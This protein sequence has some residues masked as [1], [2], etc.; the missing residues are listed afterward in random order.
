MENISRRHFFYRLSALLLTGCGGREDDGT[1][2]SSS[3]TAAVSSDSTNSTV[4]IE[5]AV[6]VA[7]VHPG[8][9]HTD[10]DF[11]RMRNKV[12][13][14]ASPWID[15]WN[16]LVDNYHAS[17][18]RNPSPCAVISRG[19]DHDNY[20]T[21]FND[22]AAAYACALRWKVS[23]DTAYAEHAVKYLDEWSST[24]TALE[25]NSNVVLAAGI[26]GYELAN[27]GEIVR[28]YPGW[29]A[30][31]LTRFQKMMRT[32]F[33]PINY[34][35]LNGHNG[36]DITHYWANW[37][38]CSIA[39]ILAIGVL[40]D[41]A[42]L[43]N[44]AIFYFKNGAGNGCIEQAVYYVHPGNLGQWQES[45]RDQGHN[46]MGIALGGAI[47]EMAWNQN[48]DLYGYD[49]NRFLAGA[50]YVAKTNLIQS[51]STYYTVPYVTYQ[52]VDV[53]QTGLSTVAQ[54]IE[55]P[56]WALVANHYINRKGLAAPY[57]KKFA[58]LIEPEGGGG[59]YGPNSGGFDQLGYGTLTCTRDPGT[60]VATPI[61]LI[62]YASAGRVVLSWWGTSNA[63]SYNVKRAM[64]SGGPYTT[65]RIGI[66]DPLTFTD[67]PPSVGTYYY[68]VTAVTPSGETKPS[69]ERK[70]VTALHVQTYLA[71]D[72]TSGTTAADSSANGHTGTLKG[73]AA[74]AAGHA[75]N[76]VSLNGAG[77]Y[78]ALPSN[79]MVNLSDFTISAWVLWN[80]S[81]TW[82]RIFD[83]GAG[84]GRYLTLMPCNGAGVMEFATTV[85]GPHGT[86]GVTGASALPV[87]Q[88][89]HVAVTLSGTTATL[90][91]NGRAV[92]ANTE[93]FLAPFRLGST[94][95]N[96]LGRSQFAADPTFNGRIDEFRIHRGAL[97]AAQVASLT[98]S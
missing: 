7:F 84:T 66:T 12:A 64:I 41:D 49:N 85:N 81:Q 24:L 68:V 37:D 57:S 21:L 44:E 36:T 17:L 86:Q 62:G 6:T 26:Y 75:G 32:I 33:Y 31:G 11:T 92:N 94:N 45:G 76:A 35:F 91:V 90:Y 60:P 34:A 28:S 70:V 89:T 3:D 14:K 73:G 27:V 10:V 98:N 1:E 40:C 97:T 8:L 63:R 58:D 30:A 82:A 65:I 93:M 87:G 25:G 54:G 18:S 16:M 46:T 88:W 95:Q 52:N 48:V 96:W 50:E 59:N 43:F 79:L 4:A 23:D 39:S 74:R 83:F 22:V 56:C 47:C 72:E 15:G 38:L 20:P 5:A 29:S 9:L 61:N 71:F 51:G 13:A 67:T 2:A 78:V 69:N 53:T 80:A 77:A 55:R 19:T 42:A